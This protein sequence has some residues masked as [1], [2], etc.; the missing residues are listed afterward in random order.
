M[1]RPAAPADV[2]AIHALIR[3]LALYEKLEHQVTGTADSLREHLFGARRYAEAIVAE[4]GGAVVGFALYFHNYST[5]LARPGIYLEDL[6]VLPDHRRRGHGRAL[7]GE[8]ARIAVERGCGR[9][10]W[11]VLD[12][13]EPALR[14]YASIGAPAM[15]DWR[16]CRLTGE[17]LARLAVTSTRGA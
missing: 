7:L 8:L 14:F 6:F 3:A 12:W 9:L 13:N 17:G 15:P 2:P 5:F 4:E 1:I 10:E 11:S 16:I